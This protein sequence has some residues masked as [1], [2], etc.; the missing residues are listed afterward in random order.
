MVNPSQAISIDAPIGGWNAFD[1]MDNMPPDSAVE[2]INLIPKSGSVDTRGGTRVF[3]DTGTGLPVETVVSLD[4]DKRS[5]LVSASDGGIWTTDNDV[6]LIEISSQG[7]F[8][9][10]KWQTA[11]FRKLDE[12][13][14]LIMCNGVDPVQLFESP[15]YGGSLVPAIFTYGTD[16]PPDSPFVG[17]LKF[18]G[19]MYYWSDN[20]DAFWY[21]QAGSY[22]GE[23]KKFNLGAI[24]QKGGKIKFIVSWTQQDAGDGR[25][26]FIVFVMSTGE[27]LVY[28]GDDPESAGFFEMVGRYNTA[29]PLSV[30]GHDKYGADTV[31]MTKDGYVALSTIIQQG[32]TSDVPQFSRLINNAISS[33]TQIGYRFYGWD[34]QVFADQGL[35]VFNVPLGEGSDQFEQHVLNTVTMKWCKFNGIQVNCLGLF[36]GRLMGG[37]GEGRVIAMLEGFNDLD[38]AILFTALPAFNYLQNPGIQK[39]IS[40]A[41]VISTHR[42]PEMIELTGF[43]DFNW[44][45]P[46]YWLQQP[47]LK[48]IGEWADYQPSSLW[49]I[50]LWDTIYWDGPQII[51][52]S[53]WDEDYWGAAPF[54]GTTKGWQNVTAFGYAVSVMIRFLKIN[55]GVV[56]RSTGIRFNNA[57]A[58]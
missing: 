57:G 44:S 35:F 33:R 4:T 26:D 58:Q 12:T 15:Y 13:G 10:S 9:S 53:F 1:S 37:D 32:R 24:A 7:T 55:S 40:A 31:I 28:Q 49:D 50:P 54:V 47:E 8:E 3:T 23:V 39:F 34:C 36:D 25:D 42:N 2:L 19:R 30:R 46:N 27:V 5:M 14:V 51:K 38:E 16:T 48:R 29:E 43:S 21:S 18:K 41:Q 6:D 11:N 52:G 22:Q 45:Y 20:D 17:C 56:W